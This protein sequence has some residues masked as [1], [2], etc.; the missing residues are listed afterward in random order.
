LQDYLL[1]EIKRGERYI[2]HQGDVHFLTAFSPRGI[3][4]EILILFSN[5]STIDEVD[6]EDWAHFSQGMINVFQYLKSHIISFNLSLFS[7]TVEGVQS[8]STEGF[9]PE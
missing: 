5:R 9:A 7:G 3:F 8:W 6:T 2:G 4:G 1:E